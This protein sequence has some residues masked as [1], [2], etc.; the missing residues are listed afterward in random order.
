MANLTA[1]PRILY[2]AVGTKTL[3][4]TLSNNTEFPVIVNSLQTYNDLL[5]V[6][7][8]I[9]ANSYAT[10]TAT[11]A[12]GEY[13]V[14]HGSTDISYVIK[15]NGVDVTPASSASGSASI[16]ST[17]NNAVGVAYNSLTA[18]QVRALLSI[19]LWNKG[20]LHASSLV[21]KPLSIWANR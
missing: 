17:A 12:D 5:I 18:A 2:T 1:T 10:Y 13:F 11:L 3:E 19:D 20:A 6:N 15:E 21:V 9:E 14:A 7:T 16:L 8:Y 4:I